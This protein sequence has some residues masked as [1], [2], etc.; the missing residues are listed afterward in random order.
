MKEPRWIRALIIAI[1]VAFVGVF[2]I[3]PLVIVFATALRDGLRTY[4]GSLVDPAALH[5]LKL[6]AI[7][8]GIS[9]PFNLLFGI[10]AS[11]AIARFRFRGRTLLITLIDLPLS[12]SPVI[13]GML[14]V[15]LFGTRGVFGAWLLAHHVQIIYALPGIVLATTFV[16]FPYVA[17]EL[18]PLME[19]QGH[20]EEEAALVLGATPWQMFRRI[21]LPKI[22]WGLVYGTILCTARAIGEFGAVSVVSGHVRNKTMTLPLHIEAL[23]GDGAYSAAFAVASVLVL[24]ALLGLL[25][26]RLIAA[27]LREVT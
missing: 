22:A 24:L 23:Y 14:F 16:T 11:W 8:A 5:A 4:F 21:T 12:I 17:R 18:I 9:V 25:V 10:A 15:L 13:A 6:T 7:A 27:R 20:E 2:V 1:V 19:S 3:A 26:R